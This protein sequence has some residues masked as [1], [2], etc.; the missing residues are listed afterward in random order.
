MT[1][2]I[3]MSEF[4]DAPELPGALPAAMP[5]TKVPWP[6][7]SPGELGRSVVMFTFATTRAP[8][9]KSGRLASMPEST[10]AIVGAF[11]AAFQGVLH[12]GRTPEAVGQTCSEDGSADSRTGES[13]VTVRPGILARNL[14][15]FALRVTAALSTNLYLPVSRSLLPASSVDLRACLNASTASEAPSVL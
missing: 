15:F 9:S 4:G 2:S 5:A 3:T 6:R 7:P 13:G 11:G 14:I 8:L 1:S 12:R 10:I